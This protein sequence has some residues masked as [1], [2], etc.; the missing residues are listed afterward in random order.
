MF[1]KL[2]VKQI[3]VGESCVCGYC[4]LN[5]GFRVNKNIKMYDGGYSLTCVSNGC[6][7]NS[8]FKG[9]DC[10]KDV[11]DILFIRI[12]VPMDVMY[13]YFLGVGIKSQN[14]SNI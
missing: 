5:V 4:L 8:F 14:F 12:W 2:S 7:I 10:H 11:Q 3:H 1:C 9:N 6:V 13:P